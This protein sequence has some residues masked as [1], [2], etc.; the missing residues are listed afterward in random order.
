MTRD[1][2]RTISGIQTNRGAVLLN[3]INIDHILLPLIC[4]VL[5]FGLLVL[6]SASN[7]DEGVIL[8]QSI[9]I[10]LGFILMLSLIHI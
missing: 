10:G 6:R 5:L 2:V 9:R 8:S 3:R 7:G 4:A 1:F